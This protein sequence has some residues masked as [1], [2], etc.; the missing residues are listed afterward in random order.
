MEDS[1]ASV[2]LRSSVV[3]RSWAET[4]FFFGEVIV[5]ILQVGY[6]LLGG[7]GQ[8]VCQSPTFLVLAVEAGVVEDRLTVGPYAV[9]LL[10]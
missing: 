4:T 8:G 7:G 5:Q 10:G 3:S 1:A 9:F 2:G 6:E